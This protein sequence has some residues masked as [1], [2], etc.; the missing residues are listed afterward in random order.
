MNVLVVS[1]PDSSPLYVCRPEFVV[2]T[3]DLTDAKDHRRITSQQ[4]L[5]EWKTYKLAIEQQPWTNTTWY[6]M[7][8]NHD[9]FDLPSWQSKVNLYRTY[10]QSADRVAH[11]QGIYTWQHSP[12]YGD[13]QFVAIDAW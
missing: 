3:G 5:E 13:Y 2:V 7:R 1:V 10:G 9:C 11:G 6:D 4:Y 12:S 8:G